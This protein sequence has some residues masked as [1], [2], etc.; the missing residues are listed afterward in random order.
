MPVAKHNL[1]NLVFEISASVDRVKLGCVGVDCLQGGL[2]N[3][4]K[5]DS[6]TGRSLTDLTWFA[7]S[8]FKL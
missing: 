8:G 5:V 1:Q 3:S 6:D 7:S 2:G 4:N